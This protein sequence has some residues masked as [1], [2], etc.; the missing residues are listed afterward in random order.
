ML[1]N[2]YYLGKVHFDD[3]WYPGKHE[4]LVDQ[5]LFDRVGA[6]LTAKNYAGEKHRSH[7][8]YL[9]G[10]VFC[11]S[12][13]SRLC[14][15]FNRG[16]GGL[17]SYFFCIG[18]QKRRT[19]CIQRHLR[20]ELVEDL[21]E[22]FYDRVSLKAPQIAELREKVEVQIRTEA[23]GLRADVDRQQRRLAKLQDERQKLLRAH[24]ADAI[25]LDML[26]TEMERIDRKT[27]DAENRLKDCSQPYDQLVAQLQ[28][29]EQ[30]I[31]S[32]ATLYR[33]GDDHTRRQVN[34]ALWKQLLLTED[35]VVDAVPTGLIRRF[36]VERGVAA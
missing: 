24:Y 34:Q 29:L 21:V 11:G 14:I 16:R 30:F 3:V 35:G 8:H 31:A 27:L 22:Q 9:K 25:P 12:C 36:G 15:S 5:R 7:P 19:A 10:S 13:G 33:T 17:Y 1:R 20:V 6:M 23:E 26:K 2:P 28:T 32:V 4:P 18:R